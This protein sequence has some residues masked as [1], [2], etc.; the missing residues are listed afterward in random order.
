MSK[1][2]RYGKLIW[3]YDDEIDLKTHTRPYP[4]F[5]FQSLK[6]N[7]VTRQPSFT[8]KTSLGLIKYQT[9]DR[10]SF[11]D[12]YTDWYRQRPS[13]DHDLSE[14]RSFLRWLQRHQKSIKWTPKDFKAHDY[15]LAKNAPHHDPNDEMAKGLSF[16]VSPV[17]VE[18]RKVKLYLQDESVLNLISLPFGEDE[19][20]LLLVQKYVKARFQWEEWKAPAPPFL[21]W[22]KAQAKRPLFKSGQL[23]LSLVTP[24]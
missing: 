5:T 12:A 2:L 11:K 13:H 22:V 7:G 19:D 14:G 16:S 4:I 24:V 17:V 8:D 1:A 23:G 9:T 3:S 20:F 6:I 18:S 21:D 10:V 15:F